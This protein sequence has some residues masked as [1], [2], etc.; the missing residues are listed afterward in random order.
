MYIENKSNKNTELFCCVPSVFIFIGGYMYVYI[1]NACIKAITWF[2]N[3][4]NY[5]PTN[6][7]K[8]LFY[9]F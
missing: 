3:F 9:N 1:P 4:I 8:V 2:N 6:K 5:G 7:A